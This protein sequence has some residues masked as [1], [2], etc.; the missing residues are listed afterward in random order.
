MNTRRW[1][2]PLWTGFALSLIAF[3]SYFAFF[4]AFELTRD[5]PWV[6]VL[7]V[8]AAIALLVAGFRRAHRKLLPAIVAG[9]GVAVFVF[10]G[11]IVIFSVGTKVPDS[12][13]AP[14]I[15][16][17]APEFTLL[18]TQRRPVALSGLL[19][20]APRGVLLVFYRGHW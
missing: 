19:A 9:I 1:N 7:L 6:N 20:S 16:Q 5:V 3:I 15:G 13:N 12:P 2:W 11:I 8:L 10:F 18:D 4:S 17:K 14:Q